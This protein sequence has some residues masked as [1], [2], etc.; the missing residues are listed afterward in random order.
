M[1]V[2]HRRPRLLGRDRPPFGQIRQGLVAHG[3]QRLLLVARRALDL[4]LAGDRADDEVMGVG[5]DE[6]D[7]EALGSVT[8]IGPGIVLPHT[9]LDLL[10]WSA[11]YIGGVAA[12]EDIEGDFHGCR[13]AWGASTNSNRVAPECP[14]RREA[15]R[16]L[17]PP[18][19]AP[20]RGLEG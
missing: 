2:G 15:S 9:C 13:L 1:R 4:P 18:S 20:C 10:I 3:D 16:T 17:S 14:R 5:K 19:E 6:L 12:A 11:R 8:V 7:R